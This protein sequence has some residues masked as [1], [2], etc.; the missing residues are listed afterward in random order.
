MANDKN[1]LEDVTLSLRETT[2]KLKYDLENSR[3][4]MTDKDDALTV[5]TKQLCRLDEKYIRTTEQM[6]EFRYCMKNLEQEVSHLTEVCSKV[7][8]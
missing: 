4:I 1:E 6:N 8:N 2:E 5:L 3:Q 7:R